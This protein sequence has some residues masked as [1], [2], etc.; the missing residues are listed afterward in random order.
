MH[1]SSIATC[2]GVPRQSW[3]R[4]LAGSIP[5]TVTS[6]VVRHHHSECLIH[7]E[8][9]CLDPAMSERVYALT[10][11]HMQR[12]Q[13]D[14]HA[15]GPRNTP[16]SSGA[17]VEVPMPPICLNTPQKNSTPTPRLHRQTRCRSRCLRHDSATKLP[18]F[19]YLNRPL[20]NSREAV[21]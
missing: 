2:P 10:R 5:P 15:R 18:S 13:D 1:V 11:R 6:V 7:K 19:P 4:E 12:I 20:V 8:G 14:S 3:K 21:Q 9:L 17:Q 16:T